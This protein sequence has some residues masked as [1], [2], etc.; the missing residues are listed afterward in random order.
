MK[1]FAEWSLFSLF[2]RHC[3]YCDVRIPG[4]RMLC[5][6]C[7]N[8]LPRI[9]GE[10]CSACGREKKVCTCKKSANYFTAL[11]A[12]FY[13][14]GAV[15]SGIHRFKFRGAGLNARA[16]ASEMAET[17]RGRYP[18][19]DFDYITEVPVTKRALRERGYNQCS[20][21]S[22]NL[23]ELLGI[24][25]RPGILKKIYETEKQHGLNY[26]LRRGNLT[27]VFDSDSPGEIKD[28]TILLCDDISTS[29]ETLN[30]CA[31]MLW[32]YGAKDVYCITLALTKMRGDK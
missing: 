1:R 20:L 14:E 15:R 9:A 29:G 28:K 21:I 10:I 4:S 27:G 32:L 6:E 11:A 3:P 19:I 5:E 26:Y 25:F 24:P 2:P 22:K 13:Y 23:S 31:K 7:E 18:G 8:N 16:Y 12:P 17:V 30:E